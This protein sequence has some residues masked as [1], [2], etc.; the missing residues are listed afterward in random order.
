MIIP[1]IKRVVRF[2]RL[3]GKTIKEVI[4]RGFVL[5]I[6]FTDGTFTELE[7]DTENSSKIALVPGKPR[8][9]QPYH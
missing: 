4:D 1:E 7:T 9:R 3:E 2:D 8:R 6:V 5:R